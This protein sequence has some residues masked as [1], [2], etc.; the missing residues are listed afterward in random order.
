VNATFYDKLPRQYLSGKTHR[1]CWGMIQALYVYRSKKWLKIGEV[2]AKCG[3][4]YIFK[5]YEKG[6]KNA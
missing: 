5:R 3:V 1:E 4:V 6:F 2:C